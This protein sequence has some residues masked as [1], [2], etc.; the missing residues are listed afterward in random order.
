[1]GPAHRLCPTNVAL[2]A[3]AEKQEEIERGTNGELGIPSQINENN[4]TLSTE[5]WIIT[6]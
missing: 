4:S 5:E 6:E 3:M 1:V 2:Q